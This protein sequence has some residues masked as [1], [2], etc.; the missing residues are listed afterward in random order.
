MKPPS[1]SQAQNRNKTL[2]QVSQIPQFHERKYDVKVDGGRGENL[3][4]LDFPTTAQQ[5]NLSAAPQE[6]FKRQKV[7]T[8]HYL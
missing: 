6:D 5:Q 2:V 4:T 1:L 8:P 3:T 7:P